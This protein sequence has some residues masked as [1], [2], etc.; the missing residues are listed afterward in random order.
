MRD[1]WFDVSVSN[2]S[3]GYT[4]IPLSDDS[5]LHFKLPGQESREK[6][7]NPILSLI[8]TG[9]QFFPSTLYY[10]S[11]FSRNGASANENLELHCVLHTQKNG[12]LMKIDYWWA[13]KENDVKLN[14][15]SSKFTQ[16]CIQRYI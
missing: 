4:P 7:S 14:A 9:S 12:N 6:C 10:F 8:I 11:S 1:Q 15:K 13:N 2:T 16:L 3:Q 5:G